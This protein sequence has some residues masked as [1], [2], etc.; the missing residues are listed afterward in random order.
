MRLG[1]GLIWLLFFGGTDC[2]A[3]NTAY[4]HFD[5]ERLTQGRVLWLANCEGCHGYGTAGAP[6]PMVPAEWEG[7]LGKARETLYKH[8]IEGF[9][10]PDDTMMPPRGGNEALTDDEVRAAVDY[11]AALAT[12]YLEQ[13]EI[14]Q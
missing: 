4:R 8:A 14:T 2:L 13:G 11:M 7:R 3:D 10:G 9:F 12:S 1:Y 5:G 6:I